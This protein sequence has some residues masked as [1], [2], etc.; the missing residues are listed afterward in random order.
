MSGL[1]IKPAVVTG[2]LA[3]G[4]LVWAFSGGPPDGVTGAPSEALCVACH[5]SFPANS[6][7]GSLTLT[8]T[9]EYSPNDTVLISVDLAHTG[10]MR[11]GFEATILDAANN[12]VGSLLVVDPTHTQFS[13]AGSGR[14]YVKHTS[15][16]TYLGT[17]DASPGWTF[18]WIAPATSAGPVTI[19]CA[20]NAANGNLN[21]QG[22]YIYT[23][24]RVIDPA[25]PPPCCTGLTGNVN[26][27]PADDV[28]LTDLTKLVNH[29]FVTF[30]S[31]PCPAEANTNGDPD[32][33]VT[34]TDLTVLVNT[35]FVTFV[36]PSGCNSFDESMCQ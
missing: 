4:T 20:G 14:Q 34:L 17:L 29:L 24:S 26:D 32:C 16:G 15:T 9:A 8:T 33:N 28:T 1:F 27:D 30:E 22:D 2:V 13:L 23:A 21:N 10:Q 6:G 19:W 5:T 12:P 18:A 11:W 7:S 3:L 25:P 36:P 31:L 35:L